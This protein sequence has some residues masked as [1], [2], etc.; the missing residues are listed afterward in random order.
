MFVNTYLPYCY[1]QGQCHA[2]LTTE[3]NFLFSYE[4]IH[5]T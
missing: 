5:D 2:L 1:L 3:E 4:A